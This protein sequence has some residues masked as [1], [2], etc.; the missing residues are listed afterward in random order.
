MAKLAVVD[1]RELEVTPFFMLKTIENIPKSESAGYAVYDTME[2]VQVQIAGDRNNSPIFPAHEQSHREG[3]RVVTYAERWA[4]QYRDF[5]EGETQQAGGTPLEVL[6]S[7]GVTPEQTSLCRALKIYS[8]EALD[9]LEGQKVK[10]LGMHQNKL[11]ESARRYM[12]DRTSGTEALSQIA[13]LKAQIAA[14]TAPAKTEVEIDDAMAEADEAMSEDDLRTE[15]ERMTGTKP[16]HKCSRET[17][18]AMYN[19]A[20]AQ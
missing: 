7:F 9:S 20:S 5:K 6:Q 18:L 17:L 2:V 16:H 4:D 3:S 15:L 12:A 11:K 19:E 13:E 14:L 10:S 8:V 1:V